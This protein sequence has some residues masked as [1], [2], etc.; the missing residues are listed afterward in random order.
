MSTTALFVGDV[1]WD[2][3]V[4]AERLPSQDEKVVARRCIEDVGGVAANAAVAC[5]LAGGTAILYS[6]IGDDAPG[7]SVRLALSG[8][9]IDSRLCATEGRTTRAIIIL[10]DLGEKRLFLAP[11]AAM[12][13][14]E[15]TLT[16]LSLDGVGWVH[17]ALYDHRLAEVLID[18]CRSAGVRWS[19]DLEPATIPPEIDSIA[20]HLSGCQTVMLNLRAS[21]MLG[22][23]AARVL[24]DMGAAEV[25]ETLG[26]EGVRHH[27]AGAEPIQVAPARQTEAVVDT[28]GAGDA[29]AGWYVAERVSG[30]PLEL[31][32]GRAVHAASQSVRFLGASA[33]YQNRST[34]LEL[35]SVPPSEER[36][37]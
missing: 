19:I 10:D 2:T 15:A 5:S 27:R 24:L 29:F 8:R 30:T 20:S 13:P 1:S 34:I 21:A 4:Q 25:V 37:Q 32:L 26:A 3:T 14:D 12:Y 28:T 18:R 17:T 6:S 23:N 22:P 7:A 36:P 16:S 35:F 31:T 33:S 11:G 9:G